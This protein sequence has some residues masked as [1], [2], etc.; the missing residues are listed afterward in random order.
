MDVKEKDSAELQRKIQKGLKMMSICFIDPVRAEEIFQKLH[1]MK[2]NNI[3]KALSQLLDPETTF[4]NAHAIRVSCI[5]LMGLVLLI[6]S[7]IQL[8]VSMVFSCY[9]NVLSNDYNE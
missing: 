9:V 4:A 3:F 7:W 5:C 6:D 1:Q 2:D 8:W